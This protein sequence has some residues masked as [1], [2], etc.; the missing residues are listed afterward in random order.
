M[1]GNFGIGTALRKMLPE[2]L[3]NKQRVMD[4]INGS[5]FISCVLALA[6]SILGIIFSGWIATNIYNNASLSLPLQI[7]SA[8]VF[9]SVIM[10]TTFGALVGV[11]KVK[12]AAVA[13]ILY[14]TF[15]LIASVPLVLPD[16]G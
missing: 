13:D 7:A 1:G 12:E 3:R 8:V 2:N 5:Y 10:N 9:L 6:I 15:Q 16:T 11:D 4:L 14:S